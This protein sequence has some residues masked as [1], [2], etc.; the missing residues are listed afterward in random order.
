MC[1]VSSQNPDS[2]NSFFFF[3]TF[4][5]ISLSSRLQSLAPLSKSQWCRVFFPG[6]SQLI[7][8]DHPTIKAAA[9]ELPWQHLV[10]AVTA[11]AERTGR[12][13]QRVRTHTR[14]HTQRHAT[15][16]L[17]HTGN[18]CS[19]ALTASGSVKV[20]MDLPSQSQRF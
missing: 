8:C 3:L 14:T 2:F 4:H 17:H 19:F 7:T 20:I 13:R 11:T 12:H 16:A 1:F 6:L 18:P 9:I 5:S 15:I 10:H